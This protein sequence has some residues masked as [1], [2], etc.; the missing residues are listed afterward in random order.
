MP[1]SCL[2]PP[3]AH[4]PMQPIQTDQLNVSAG[5]NNQ[6]F[7]NPLIDQEL[8]IERELEGN[9]TAPSPK[10]SR[11]RFHRQ[12]MPAPQCIQRQEAEVGIE[13]GSGFIFGFNQ[14]CHGGDAG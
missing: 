8:L 9:M 3:S 2:S 10:Q 14:H 1:G 11:H 4:G 13:R 6:R 12:K 7:A 5:R